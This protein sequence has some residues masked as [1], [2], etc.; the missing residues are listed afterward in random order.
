MAKKK[1]KQPTS[2][3]STPLRAAAGP[4][5]V[6]GTP[7]RAETKPSPATMQGQPP[8][9]YK[10]PRPLHLQEHAG[11]CLKQPPNFA[12]ASGTI[13][14]PVL[15]GEF[16]TAAQD[17][18]IVF[19]PGNPAVPVIFMG[20]RQGENYFIQPDGSWLPGAYIPAYLRRY[21]FLL[22]ESPAAR[23]RVLFVDEAAPM[24]SRDGG[25]PLIADGKLTETANAALKFSEAYAV[26][27]ENTRQF[28]EAIAEHDLLETRNI[29]LALPKGKITLQDVRVI[30]PRKFEELPD[31]VY[32]EWRKKRW[33][34]PAYAHFQ[35][36]LNWQRLVMRAAA[37]QA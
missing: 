9:L 3:A 34:F 6:G 7:S 14:V 29:T 18:P 23:R 20:L 24:L 33:L 36:G 27:Q 4:R 32:L 8:L 19:G 37:R 31:S 35:S 5:A 26:D 12:F 1:G 30:S 25:T 28:A 13:A 15:V 11:L 2:S 16:L 21:P 22:V 10:K 17:Y